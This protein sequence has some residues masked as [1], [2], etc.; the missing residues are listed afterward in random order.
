MQ[1]YGDPT[2]SRVDCASAT[3]RTWQFLDGE[4]T[5][6]LD[7]ALVE[8]IVRCR[9]CW[10]GFVAEARMKRIVATK[11]AGERAPERLRRYWSHRG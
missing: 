9:D 4:C 8:H 7:R 1:T 11:C 3:A 6:E 5:P 10:D 2:Q